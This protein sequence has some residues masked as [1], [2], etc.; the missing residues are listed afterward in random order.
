MKYIKMSLAILGTLLLIACATIPKQTEPGLYVNG[1]P[2]FTLSYPTDWVEKTP[3]PREA[4]RAE[5]PGGAPS[6]RIGVIPN[7]S[8]PL[9]YSTRLV[10]PE[11]AKI[12]KD[13]KVI[14]D[15]ETKL[16][17]GTPAQEAEL[18][19]VVNPGIKVYTLFLTTQKED[20]WIVDQRA[21]KHHPLL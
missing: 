11:L 3:D 18:E 5:A 15:K 13:I 16:E 10:I 4:F 17:D 12:G 8:M 14:H 9:K 20:I 19:W 2:A 21:G 1:W 6:L 7:M